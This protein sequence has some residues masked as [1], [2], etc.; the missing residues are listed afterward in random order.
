MHSPLKFGGDFLK[1]FDGFV[2]DLN[3]TLL[4][5]DIA[6][7][8]SHALPKYAMIPTNHVVLVFSDSF[9]I[10][11]DSMVP[12]I[13]CDFG[14]HSLEART[15]RRVSTGDE[16]VS[17]NHFMNKGPF[18]LMYFPAVRFED[19][20]SKID[21]ERNLVSVDVSKAA[22]SRSCFESLVPDHP[23]TS[24][25]IIEMLLIEALKHGQDIWLCRG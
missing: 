25:L 20:L 11:S 4:A 15:M 17:M 23:N 2:C 10:V 6:S 24:Y 12:I 22:T 13:A 7:A 5:D 19:F 18:D 3:P 14:H 8:F 21:F 1:F 16:Q 9:Q